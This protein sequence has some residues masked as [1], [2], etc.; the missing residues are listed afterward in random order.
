MG[1]LKPVDKHC[2]IPSYLQVIN[3]IKAEIILGRF[4]I[5]DQLP[6]VRELERIFD[7]NVNTV[8]KALDKLKNEGIVESEQGIGYFVKSD[9]KVANE[10][11]DEFKIL[12]RK[13]K[14]N[15]IDLQ[16]AQILLSEVWKNEKV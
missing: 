11:V 10:L 16:T 7:V 9:L 12:V 5:G 8:L 13:C 15:D 4:K 3:Q 6:T 1:M 2:G 14:E